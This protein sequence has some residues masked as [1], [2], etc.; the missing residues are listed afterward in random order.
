M[1]FARTGS[2]TPASELDH[3]PVAPDL[4][5]H[6]LGDA[7]LVG[8]LAEHLEGPL[9]IHRRVGRDLAR[10]IELEREVHSALEVQAE[11]D[12]DPFDLE[13]PHHAVGAP[14]ADGDLAGDQVDDCDDDQDPD[15]D[16][17]VTKVSEHV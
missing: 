13:V 15:D 10:L 7:E 1:F 5:H 17:P 8:T 14:L 9:D 4:L 16:Q 3:D 11:P 12:R 2:V 6:R